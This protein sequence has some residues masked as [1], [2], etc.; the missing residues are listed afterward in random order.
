MNDWDKVTVRVVDHQVSTKPCPK[1]LT[2]RHWRREKEHED[3][4]RTSHFIFFGSF[5]G[6]FS[7]DPGWRTDVQTWRDFRRLFM[8][9]GFRP[10]DEELRQQLVQ[11]YR[12]WR[13]GGGECQSM[14]FSDLDE[15]DTLERIWKVWQMAKSITPEERR[16]RITAIKRKRKR[17]TL[18]IVQ[19]RDEEDLSFTEIQLRLKRHSYATVLSR[20]HA[21]K[22]KQLEKI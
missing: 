1:V 11:R 3:T 17:E 7:V 10:G 4:V 22:Q 16:K 21:Y 9:E 2:A 6:V 13:L 15:V 20:Y 14:F 8:E 18:R 12:G 19:L 5:R